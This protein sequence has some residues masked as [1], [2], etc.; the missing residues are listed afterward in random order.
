[1]YLNCLLIIGIK[2]ELFDIAN[3]E[4]EISQT[5]DLEFFTILSLNEFNYRL[6]K[7]FKILNHFMIISCLSILEM[8]IYWTCEIIYMKKIT[9]TQKIIDFIKNNP[10]ER[11]AEIARGIGV[12]RSRKI[13]ST[14]ERL[15]QKGKIH[16][17]GGGYFI[18]FGTICILIPKNLY[19]NDFIA[20]T[21][22]I[23]LQISF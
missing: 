21:L 22:Q 4:T 6:D 9:R 15:R 20:K 7:N 18:G 2:S 16:Q 1:M 13:A 14:L 23:V 5:N 3:K 11:Q 10:G 12:D 19:I 8:F 17:D